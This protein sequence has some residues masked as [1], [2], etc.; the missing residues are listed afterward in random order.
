MRRDVPTKSA[1]GENAKP[2]ANTMGPLEGGTVVLGTKPTVAAARPSS[3]R[4][5]LARKPPPIRNYNVRD[6][7]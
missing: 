2:N 1:A 4:R 6:E 7:Q 3:P 5:T